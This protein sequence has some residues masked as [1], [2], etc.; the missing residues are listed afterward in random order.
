MGYIKFVFF[1][2]NLRRRRRRR[3]RKADNWANSIDFYFLV[4]C[5]VRRMLLTT[6][7]SLLADPFVGDAY[8]ATCL[9]NYFIFFFI[10]STVSKANGYAN[11]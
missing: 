11:S 8:C 3:R 2:W 10:K 4:L 6:Y 7:G 1:A 9:Q 5:Y